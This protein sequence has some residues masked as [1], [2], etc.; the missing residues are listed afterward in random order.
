MSRSG[1]IQQ[2]SRAAWTSL[3]VAAAVA[4][5]LGAPV[6][7][8]SSAA[9][10][11]VFDPLAVLR[12]VPGDYNCDLRLTDFEPPGGEDLLARWIAELEALLDDE[13]ETCQN[14]SLLLPIHQRD[15]ENDGRKSFST[16]GRTAL[17]AEAERAGCKPRKKASSASAKLDSVS[18]RYRK[19]TA[20][21][22]RLVGG[23][24]KASELKRYVSASYA[25]D[26]FGPSEPEGLW[27]LR[28]RVELQESL[29][30]QF[31]A[32]F[33]APVKGTA[34]NL[35]NVEDWR[36]YAKKSTPFNKTIKAG[37]GKEVLI[38]NIS[39]KYWFAQFSTGQI[40]S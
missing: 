26:K 39:T 25:V 16:E 37:R 1:P 30:D 40:H 28:R 22:A 19:A 2:P 14:A 34:R 35:E 27:G 33:L 4:L 24:A 17:L 3:V 15:R 13:L 29:L 8:D 5:V 9:A 38:E 11:D 20:K 23:K 12:E 32:Q 21:M 18:K 31:A 6:L 10:T 7:A 36:L